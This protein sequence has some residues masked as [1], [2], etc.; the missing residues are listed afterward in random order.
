MKKLLVVLGVAGA[1]AG[2]VIAKSRKC[3]GACEKTEE[4]VEAENK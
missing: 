4:H 1:V 2:V 3:E